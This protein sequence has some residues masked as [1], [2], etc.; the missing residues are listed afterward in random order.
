[1]EFSLKAD[2]VVLKDGFFA[3]DLTREAQPVVY[4]A[5]VAAEAGV[6]AC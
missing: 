2:P 3:F 5:T 6:D 1:M 4:F